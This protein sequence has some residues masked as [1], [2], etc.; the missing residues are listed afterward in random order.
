MAVIAPLQT[1]I[2]RRKKIKKLTIR[3]RRLNH[4]QKAA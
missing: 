1:I 4:Q 3:N 2:E